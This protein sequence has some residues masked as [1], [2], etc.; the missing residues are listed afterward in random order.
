ME[1]AHSSSR[2]LC[3]SQ[4]MFLGFFVPPAPLRQNSSVCNFDY[5]CEGMSRHATFENFGMAFLT[6]FQVSTGDNCQLSL[7]LAHQMAYFAL[8]CPHAVE[9]VAQQLLA[10]LLLKSF[11]PRSPAPTRQSRDA[12]HSS[13][14]VSICSPVGAHFLQTCANSSSGV[15]TPFFDSWISLRS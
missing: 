1:L 3:N 12:K 5:P 11:E 13:S 8:L 2:W 7:S 10:V 15:T 4:R 14:D 9:E 6:L